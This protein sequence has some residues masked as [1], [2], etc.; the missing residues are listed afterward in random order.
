MSYL[1]AKY[2]HLRCVHFVRNVQGLRD[3]GE[4]IV[5]D[6]KAT[7]VKVVYVNFGDFAFSPHTLATILGEPLDLDFQPFEPP[8]PVWVRFSDSMGGLSFRLDGL[9]LI[10]DRADILFERRMDE[11]YDLIDSFL[12]QLHLWY[13]RK[14]PCNLFFQLEKSDL[15]RRYFGS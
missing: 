15:V 7:N 8:G 13:D 12:S 2:A 14:K 11:V 5:A 9:A 3:S 6:L 10:I 4:E 1:A